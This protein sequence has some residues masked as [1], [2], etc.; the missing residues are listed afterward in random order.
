MGLDQTRHREHLAMIEHLIT[1]GYLDLIA[2]TDSLDFTPRD[3]DPPVRAE[4]QGTDPALV[5]AQ[6]HPEV[7][8]GVQ[9][10]SS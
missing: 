9:Y 2:R 6:R 4:S 7:I 3:Q 1:L 5:P 8:H 10:P